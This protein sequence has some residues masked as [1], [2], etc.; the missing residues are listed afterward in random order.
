MYDCKTCPLN[1]QGDDDPICPH[2]PSNSMECIETR[3]E[4]DN[5]SMVARGKGDHDR[6]VKAMNIKHT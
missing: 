6:R 1:P 5:A 4:A 2:M 3:V